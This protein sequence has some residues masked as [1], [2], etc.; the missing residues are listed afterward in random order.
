M[1]FLYLKRSLMLDSTFYTWSKAWSLML[2][3]M[4]EEKLETWC[5]FLYLKRSVKLETMLE[6]K[7]WRL[8]NWGGWPTS[9]HQTTKAQEVY[10][11]LLQ[12]WNKAR[13]PCIWN[14]YFNNYVIKWKYNRISFHSS[15]SV[16]ILLAC[17]ISF[18]SSFSVYILLACLEEGDLP[19]EFVHIKK[20]GVFWLQQSF[21]FNL[22]V[23]WSCFKALAV[24]L[25]NL[26]L[27]LVQMSGFSV[28]GAY[29]NF[30]A[31]VTVKLLFKC[32]FCGLKRGIPR[33]FARCVLS[34]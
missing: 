3:F 17:R 2:P 33:R 29:A 19:W 23:I 21:L 28:E 10:S 5:Y 7:P 24:N 34:Q 31:F 20:N 4:L 26:F 13:P 22:C 18:H 14:A 32:W 16:Y 1:L 11:D 8:V 6:E 30:V 27:P 15:F 25:F 12:S 9:R